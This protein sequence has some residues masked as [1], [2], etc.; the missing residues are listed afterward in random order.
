MENSGTIIYAHWSLQKYRKEEKVT[1]KY[2][3]AVLPLYVH[4]DSVKDALSAERVYDIHC[5]TFGSRPSA[6]VTWWIGKSQLLDHSSQVCMILD[7]SL[8][9]KYHHI[10]MSCCSAVQAGTKDTSRTL[11]AWNF[12]VLKNHKNWEGNTLSLSIKIE[13]SGAFSVF[14]IFKSESFLG[15]RAQKYLPLQQGNHIRMMIS[16]K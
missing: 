9:Y 2:S 7:R 4:I 5:I 13:W 10:R 11:K 15:L 1:F 8:F 14:V 3:F 6:L 12:H 16:T